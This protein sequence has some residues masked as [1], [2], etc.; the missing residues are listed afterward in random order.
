MKAFLALLATL[1]VTL[2]APAYEPPSP[3]G[4]VETLRFDWRDSARDRAVPAKM[5]FPRQNAKP[6]SVIVFSHGLGGSR[7]GYEF[8]G[9][10]WA[11]CG[12]VSV[13]LQHAGSDDAVWKDAAPA[14]RMQAMRGA[15]MNLANIA[16]RP[17]DVSFALDQLRAVRDDAG[18]PLHG[19]LDLER[20]GAAGHS[21]GG[22]TTMAIA[23]QRLGPAQWADPRVKA[24]IQMSAPIVRPAQRERAYGG[25]TIPVFHMTGT[26]DDSPIGDT[27]AEERRIAFD[28]MNSAGTCLLILKDGDHMVF[29]GAPRARSEPREMDAEFQRLICAA[30]TA[31]W[32]AWLKG[33]A[34]ARAWLMDGGFAKVLGERG[35]FEKK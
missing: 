4:A 30:S 9:R 8:L 22:F 28:K 34:T 18:S 19:R 26:R 3:G 7:E 24:A 2:P 15:T 17:K 14:E 32:D 27:K 21:F 13:H 23:G 6:L 5:Y 10:H 29:A 12:Y 33:D 31:F 25:I 11:G 1:L 16:N 35:T 20:V